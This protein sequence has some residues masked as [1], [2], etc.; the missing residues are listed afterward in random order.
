MQHLNPDPDALSVLIALFAVFLG[1]EFAPFAATYSIIFLGAL[2]GVL[3]S[4]LKRKPSTR[5]SAL[6]YVSATFLTA[7]FMTVPISSYFAQNYEVFHGSASWLF[8]PVA[9]AIT[10]YGEAWISRLKNI[11]S[12]VIKEVIKDVK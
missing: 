4:L 2:A 11:I 12:I 6:A 3:I 8:F 1:A 7:I 5:L 9:G 10:A